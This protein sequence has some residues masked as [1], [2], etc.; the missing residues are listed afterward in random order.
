MPLIRQTF[1]VSQE[2]CVERL[3]ESSFEHVDA[4]PSS[5]SVEFL[6]VAL[7]AHRALTWRRWTA[8]ATSTVA[9]CSQEQN[10]SSR[11]PPGTGNARRPPGLQR[12]VRALH[13]VANRSR[14][15][16]SIDAHAWARRRVGEYCSRRTNSPNPYSLDS[17]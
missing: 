7:L 14:A 9:T 12:R 5:R 1:T 15:Q 2:K 6:K 4:V 3:A 13:G 11:I 17:L 16:A 8:E 10:P